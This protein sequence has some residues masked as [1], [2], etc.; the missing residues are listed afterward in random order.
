M[1]S[2]RPARPQ[3]GCA[4]KKGRENI[5]NCGIRAPRSGAGTKLNT[6]AALR[7]R[8][9]ASICSTMPKD[10]PICTSASLAEKKTWL[11]HKVRATLHRQEAL[12]GNAANT[13]RPWSRKVYSAPPS[14]FCLCWFPPPSRP[15]STTAS[16]PARPPQDNRPRRGTRS[17][18]PRP[19]GQTWTCPRPGAGAAWPAPCRPPSGSQLGPRRRVARRRPCGLLR[20][21]SC[22]EPGAP[23]SP[24]RP[25]R[26]RRPE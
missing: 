22:S 7:Q 13:S 23:P 24:S 25:P 20:S 21:C 9:F 6:R 17:R 4:G 12:N 26:C 19:R 11:Q 1:R 10:P 16:L 14:P 5:G 8:H 18:R 3:L 15:S 2:T